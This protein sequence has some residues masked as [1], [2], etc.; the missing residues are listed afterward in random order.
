MKHNDTLNTV[1]SSGFQPRAG[2][3]E[4]VKFALQEKLHRR[5]Y[6]RLRWALAVGS[7]LVLLGIGLQVRQPHPT[8][9]L[10][11][12]GL[13]ATNMYVSQQFGEC[14]PRGLESQPNYVH[15]R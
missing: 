8:E 7:L 2:A 9:L 15:F 5:S 4:R 1:L 6:G 12:A 14:G 3:K 10:G 11:P 13:H